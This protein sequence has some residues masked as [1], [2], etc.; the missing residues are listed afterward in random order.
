[1]WS[2]HPACYPAAT[3]TPERNSS[4]SYFLGVSLSAVGPGS[5]SP[6]QQP[7]IPVE[8]TIIEGGKTG[9]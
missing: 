9:K 8:A 5:D 4:K 7:L 6:S 2:F 1:M 3:N